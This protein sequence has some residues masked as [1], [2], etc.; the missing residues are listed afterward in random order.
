MAGISPILILKHYPFAG[1]LSLV[2]IS[3]L[4]IFFVTS[5]DSATVV[6]GSFTSGGGL[7]VPNCK[8]VAWGLSLSAISI[9]LLVTGGLASLQVMAITVAFPFMLVM[10]ILCYTL[11]IGLSQE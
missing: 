11:V 8:K 7:I 3:L 5:A 9:M 1:I 10:L 4:I 2:A 6:P